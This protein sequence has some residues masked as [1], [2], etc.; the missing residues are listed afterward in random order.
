MN[1]EL[2]NK[3]IIVNTQWDD[4]GI[5]NISTFFLTVFW[6]I[7]KIMNEPMNECLIEW[8]NEGFAFGK[9]LNAYHLPFLCLEEYWRKLF[10]F[11]QI[12]SKKQDFA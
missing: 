3:K 7:N 1:K 12:Y 2:I 10:S 4:G 11:D 8:M 6:Q 9:Y 5:D